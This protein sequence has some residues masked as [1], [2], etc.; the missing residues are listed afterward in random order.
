M[1]RRFKT[2]LTSRNSAGFFLILA[3]DIKLYLTVQ[4]LS[5]IILFWKMIQHIYVVMSGFYKFTVISDAGQLL[6][7][8]HMTSCSILVQLSPERGSKYLLSLWL[9]LNMFPP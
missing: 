8:V 9:A 3:I 5:V 6:I 7:P 2:P 4:D 1:C